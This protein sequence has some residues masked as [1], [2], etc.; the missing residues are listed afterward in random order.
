MTDKLLPCPF[1]GSDSSL[2]T[3]VTSDVGGNEI[4]YVTCVDCSAQADPHDWQTR[5]SPE[6]HARATAL[7]E[8]A[9]IADAEAEM[10]GHTDG[11]SARVV[12]AR[13]RTLM[14]EDAAPP[15]T[16]EVGS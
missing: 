2:E 10:S 16:R 7:E 15:Q 3:G 12:A 9:K 11:S 1:C 13:I 4:H 5:P 14:E 6:N 8:A